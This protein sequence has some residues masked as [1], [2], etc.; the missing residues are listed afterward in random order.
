MCCTCCMDR[1]CNLF[2]A[3]KQFALQS[4]VVQ[5]HLQLL[6]LHLK[7]VSLLLLQFSFMPILRFLLIP[8]CFCCLESAR[9]R[10]RSDGYAAALKGE[11]CRLH[12]SSMAATGEYAS[13]APLSKLLEGTWAGTKEEPPGLDRLDSMVMSLLPHYN[14]I[15]Q[16]RSIRESSFKHP[17]GSGPHTT[18]NKLSVLACSS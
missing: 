5:P 18:R 6:I 12:L 8:S 3:V 14:R 2:T 11:L 16:Q 7:L 15:G 4:V 13:M 17:S 10:T 1:S 9:A